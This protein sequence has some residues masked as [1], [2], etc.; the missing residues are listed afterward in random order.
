MPDSP[1]ALVALTDRAERYLGE[2]DPWWAGEIP[3]VTMTQ[4]SYYC[5]AVGVRDPIHYDHEFARQAGFSGA[6][7]N[8]SLRRAWL[9]YL[10][11]AMAGERWRVDSVRCEHRGL[12]AVG[13]EIAVTV[14]WADG[15][16]RERDKALAGSDALKLSVV[17]CSENGVV[18]SGLIQFS[19]S[20]T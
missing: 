1:E 7:V 14:G 6:V 20:E 3:A 2:R 13:A 15:S 19:R 16:D 8:G 5:A 18:D 12:L 9:C 4:T 17:L 11:E 10:A